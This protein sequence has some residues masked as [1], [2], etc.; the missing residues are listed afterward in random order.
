MD[1]LISSTLQ[2]YDSSKGYDPHVLNQT[3]FDLR[4]F[5]EEAYDLDEMSDTSIDEIVETCELVCQDI[6]A[7]LFAANQ[8]SV[9]KE[10]C[11]DTIDESLQRIQSFQGTNQRSAE[12]YEQRHSMLTASIAGA[13]LKVDIPRKRGMAV[14]RN[15]IE[16]IS[17]P[18]GENTTV[19]IPSNPDAPA[20]RGNRYEPVIR[21]VYAS[22]LPNEPESNNIEE[23]VVEYD[24]VSHPEYSFLGASPDGIVMKG[25]MRGRM[26]E[27]KCPQPGS[28]DKDG[29]TVR[30]EYW[31]QMQLQ[32]EVCNLPSCDYVR[33]VVWDAPTVEEAT[34]KLIDTQRQYRT[35][36]LTP[37]IG[38][39]DAR[40]LVKG[41]VWMNAVD[42]KYIYEPP[43][44]F[45]PNDF[46]YGRKE[47]EP[48]FIRHYF[49]LVRDWMVIC[50]V[51]NRNWFEETFLPKAK[52]VWEEIQRGR[53]NPEEWLRQNP[54]KGRGGRKHE[55]VSFQKEPETEYSMIDSD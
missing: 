52:E 37:E 7:G 49:I 12:W 13:I 15:K 39:R 40:L 51:R 9:H 27:I 3:I 16:P 6:I 11:A 44:K 22:M 38:Q 47:A 10:H 53:Q 21:N 17:L 42:G 18:F 28:L 29:N 34:Q 20:V 14:I 36:S 41:T 45:V 33:A 26:V 8:T 30:H 54:K 24:C 25:P 2:E 48:A 55:F 19:S 4:C 32:M 31:C 35:G 46:I 43:G 1:E 50:V 23:I 5:L